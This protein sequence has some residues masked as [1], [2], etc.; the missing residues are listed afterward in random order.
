MRP[1]MKH[2]YVMVWLA[3]STLL[4]TG[5]AYGDGQSLQLTGEFM[6]LQASPVG[7]PITLQSQIRMGDWEVLDSVERVWL[8][9]F[10]ETVDGPP[11]L[12]SLVWAQDSSGWFPSWKIQLHSS[13]LFPPSLPDQKSLGHSAGSFVN[14]GSVPLPPDHSVEARLSFDPASGRADV[15]VLDL[16]AGHTLITRTLALQPYQGELIPVLGVEG[17]AKEGK[18]IQ[19]EHFHA[20]PTRV[21]FGLSWDVMVKEED[22]FQ[23]VMLTRLT[24]GRDMALWLGPDADDFAG[25]L[26]L[27]ADADQPKTVLALPA[28]AR[29]EPVL[30]PFRAADLPLGAVELALRYVDEEG[31]TW[32]FDGRRLQVV[33]ANLDVRFGPLAIDGELLKGQMMVTSED[34]TVE[35]LPVRVLAT[36]VKAGTK[37]ALGDAQ[38]V[39]EG[40]LDSVSPQGTAVPLTIPIPVEE[41]VFGL[42]LDV[43]FDTEVGSVATGSEYYVYR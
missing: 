36:F 9:G 28:G 43:R 23:R 29:S 4:L 22:E 31:K 8:A 42:V 40:S 17:G 27:V 19:V 20:W 21:P 5:L 26:L 41:R 38:L 7:Q 6:A 25:Q 37:E 18:A 1:W 15:A 30:L 14:L 33:V 16:T 3:A 24:V 12:L 11:E 13:K 34:E 10:S 35:G 32:S 39:F 2:Y